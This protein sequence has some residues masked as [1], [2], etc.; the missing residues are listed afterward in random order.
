M[1]PALLVRLSSAGA[2]VQA[3]LRFLACLHLN[4]V[5][6]VH[7]MPVQSSILLRCRAKMKILSAW[8]DSVGREKTGTN[9]LIRTACTF[10]LRGTSIIMV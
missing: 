2:E 1:S 7:I 10:Y 6:R 5:R 4:A 8:M 3:A 9:A